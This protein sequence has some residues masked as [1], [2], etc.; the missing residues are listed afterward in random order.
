MFRNH[1]I[2]NH[3]Y[4]IP[5][6]GATLLYFF[7]VHVFMLSLYLTSDFQMIVMHMKLPH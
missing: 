2:N 7:T 5:S 3:D 6:L 1:T 4:K